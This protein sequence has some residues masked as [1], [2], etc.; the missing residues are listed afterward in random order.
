MEE[1]MTNELDKDKKQMYSNIIMKCKQILEK[2][3]N[4][5]QEEQ[6]ISSSSSQDIIN[7]LIISSND[8]LSNWLDKLHS[9]SVTDNSIFIKLPRYYEG[10]FHKD[11]AALNVIIILLLLLLFWM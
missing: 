8:I 4:S 2:Y 3:N 11:M 7:D 5:N 10:E 1:K 9:K 6:N